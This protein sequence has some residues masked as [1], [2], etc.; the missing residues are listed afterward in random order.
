MG[1]VKRQRNI[2]HLWADKRV[3]RAFRK[4]LEK[5][6]YKNI[7]SIY[8]AL[9]EIDSDFGEGPQIYGFTKTVAT[10]A[11]MSHETVYPYLR[12]LQKA[13]IIDYEQQTSEDGRFGGTSLVMFKWEE[14]NENA[15]MKIIQN[16]LAHRMQR[17]KKTEKIAETRLR[18]N[19]ST[20]E[21]G[22]GETRPFKDTTKVVSNNKNSKESNSSSSDEEDFSNK[23]KKITASQF[24]EFWAL[25]PNKKGKGQAKT[26]WEQLCK[27]P[28]KKRPTWQKI[29]RAIIRQKRTEQWQDPQYIPWASTWL[30]QQRW[31]DD[32]A[33]MKSYHRQENQSQSKASSST[34]ASSEI[35]VDTFMESA[36]KSKDTRNIF[37]NTC[38]KPAQHYFNQ[39]DPIE[40]AEALVDIY[41]GIERTQKENLP[42]DMRRLMPGPMGILSS[43]LEWL[44]D[45][46]WIMDHSLSLLSLSGKPFG[47]F[48]RQWARDVD[49]M[50]RDA[51]TGKSYMREE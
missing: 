6:H 26:K 30:N 7:R 16:I 25:Y 1:T 43:Y 50:E 5:H 41:K 9:C 33:E 29:K 37:T 20:V 13:D 45:Q 22:N 38:L 17:T 51:I 8:L 21:P 10:Y 36:F 3:I 32:P 14:A 44:A 39:A 23:N 48:R 35:T 49:N 28:L 2:A 4:N 42:E 24:E 15:A 40:L 12:A 34:N 47:K 27:T 11:G 18:E 19:P 46:D 31:L